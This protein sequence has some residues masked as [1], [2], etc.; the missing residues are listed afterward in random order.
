M[1]FKQDG[2]NSSMCAA[3]SKENQSKSCG[4]FRVESQG[5]VMKMLEKVVGMLSSR[6]QLGEDDE[7]ER[8]EGGYD[9][10]YE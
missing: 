9:T 5:K 6:W 7:S 3:R 2:R 1:R 4:G 8:K 10:C